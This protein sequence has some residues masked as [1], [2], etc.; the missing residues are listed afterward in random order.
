MNIKNNKNIKG[1]NKPQS[2]SKND[3]KNLDNDNNAV[4]S[5]KEQIQVNLNN[6]LK[7]EDN[8][9]IKKISK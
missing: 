9:K 3:T 7:K 5:E 4:V 1:N 8:A 2:I 6:K